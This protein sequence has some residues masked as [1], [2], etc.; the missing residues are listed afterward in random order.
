MSIPLLKTKL[1]IPPPQPGLVHRP[2]LTNLI[3]EGPPR[4]FFHDLA[5]SHIGHIDVRNAVIAVHQLKRPLQALSV[6]FRRLLIL[7]RSADLY[8]LRIAN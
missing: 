8:L 5:H 3:N 7:G 4:N 1:Y 6:F 2:R